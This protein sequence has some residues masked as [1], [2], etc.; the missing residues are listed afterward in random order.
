M[1]RPGPPYSPEF[2]AEAVRLL[3]SSGK[4]VAELSHELG[5]S[6][7]TLRSW[8]RRAAVHEEGV[9]LTTDEHSRPQELER[10]NR[11]LLEERESLRTAEG[12]GRSRLPPR[13]APSTFHE[14]SGAARGRRFSLNPRGEDQ[15]VRRLA[16]F[17]AE[18]IDIGVAVVTLPARWAANSLRW[19]AAKKDESPGKPPTGPDGD[20]P[21]AAE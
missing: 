18:A 12:E 10:E 2:R 1:P 19:Y 6:E 16:R 8:R 7:Q 13:S 21:P 3:R 14:V 15:S 9:G 17:T 20:G 5:V 11:R 4:T